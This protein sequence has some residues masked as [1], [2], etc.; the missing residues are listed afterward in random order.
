MAYIGRHPQ[1]GSLES[2]TFTGDGTTTTFS[3]D[4]EV[5]SSSSILV[6]VNDVIQQPGVDYSII[7]G[8]STISFTS[9]P[10]N[11][12]TG[13]IIFLGAKLAVASVG[14]STFT[15][16]SA[17]GDGA[18]TDFTIEANRT[19]NN[20]LVV[21]NGSVQTPTTDYTISG[22]TLTFTSAPAGSATIS[23]RYLGQ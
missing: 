21:V 8:G 19:V 17:T 10:T 5:S 11:G 1:Y 23:F 14:S 12:H 13:F 3:L 9:A 2:Q 22:T 16:G 15:S 20:V 7:S 6:F 4:F 18:T